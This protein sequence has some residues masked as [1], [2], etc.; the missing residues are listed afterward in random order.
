MAFKIHLVLLI[1]LPNWCVAS[2]LQ[3]YG[4]LYSL[5]SSGPTAGRRVLSSEQRR[6]YPCVL[7]KYYHFL[8]VPCSENQN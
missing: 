7:S 5:Q 8:S 4:D 6:I 2:G 1:E 3:V